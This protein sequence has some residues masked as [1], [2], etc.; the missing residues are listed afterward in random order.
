M[1]NPDNFSEKATVLET[2]VTELQSTVGRLEFA[3]IFTLAL[4]LLLY[5]LR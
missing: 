2:K 5:I 3:V 1:D 4:M